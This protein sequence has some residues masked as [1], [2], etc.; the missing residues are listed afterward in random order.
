L[1]RCRER[2][3]LTPRSQ[4]TAALDALEKDPAVRGV[5]FCSGLKKDIFT[6]GCAAKRAAARACKLFACGCV[7]VVVVCRSNDITELYSK[8][9]TK[10][11]YTRFWHAQTS[12]L[13]RG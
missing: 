7:T 6:A 10:E 3:A 13:V 1:A 2:C 9:T 4:P 8:S 5:I 12:F 11:R